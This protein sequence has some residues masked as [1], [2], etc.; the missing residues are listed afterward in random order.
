MSHF[1]KRYI[2]HVSCKVQSARHRNN[3][4]EVFTRLFVKDLVAGLLLNRVF[5][6]FFFSDFSPNYC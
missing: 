3:A 4:E 2:L 6:N 1:K 5:D